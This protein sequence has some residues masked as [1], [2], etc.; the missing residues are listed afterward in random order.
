M[1]SCSKWQPG[2]SGSGNGG[3]YGWVRSRAISRNGPGGVRVRVVMRDAHGG[4]PLIGAVGSE[5]VGERQA[6]RTAPRARVRV[7]LI[8]G[9]RAER[10]ADLRF[11]ERRCVSPDTSTC[12]FVPPQT[13]SNPIWP[14]REGQNAFALV[15][16]TFGC[17][18]VGGG[19]SASTPRGHADGYKGPSAR[20]QSRLG[21]RE[22][23]EIE[24]Q[25]PGCLGTR[26][27]PPT[28]VS[29]RRTAVSP[30]RR[31]WRTASP[32]RWIVRRRSPVGLCGPRTSSTRTGLPTTRGAA[33]ATAWSATP[34][35]PTSWPC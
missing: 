12:G 29:G 23:Q 25:E 7:L 24:Q 8:K 9:H 22:P 35:L 19:V 3:K 33:A 28:G 17:R 31:R 32:R 4:V 18:P 14:C 2:N 16:P 13:Q 10:C 20:G 15:R 21:F 30:S 5:R 26:V 1:A 6:G 11:R 27:A 34:S